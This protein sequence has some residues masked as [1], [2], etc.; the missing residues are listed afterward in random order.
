[1]AALHAELNGLMQQ[2]RAQSGRTDVPPQQW[3]AMVS[4]A[5][6]LCGQLMSQVHEGSNE[7]AVLQ[8]QQGELQ[9]MQQVTPPPSA[10]AAPGSLDVDKLFA[11]LAAGGLLPGMPGAP[12]APVTAP[13]QGRSDGS[14][15]SAEAMVHRMYDAK[16]LQCKVGGI[17]LRFNEDQ[18]EEMREHMDKH[19]QKK[20]R[21]KAK[22][23]APASRRWMSPLQD[24]LQGKQY[25][26]S[27]AEQPALSVF[28]TLDQPNDANEAPAA[29]TS[30]SDLPVLRAPPDVSRVVCFQCGEEI[31]LFWEPATEEWMLRDA[32]HAKDGS[33][34]ICHSGCSG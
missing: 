15:Q 31:S 7:F 17:V 22:G 9:Q 30:A 16:P 5:N 18:R 1:M 24:W 3:N 20:M 26:D 14:T 25:D 29:Q 8:S 4:Q 6:S 11:S 23:S 19:F 28:D 13:Q 34:R 32:V 12:A 33:G 27:T 21:G 10:P 2:L